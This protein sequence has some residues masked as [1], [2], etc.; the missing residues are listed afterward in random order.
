VL[1]VLTRTGRVGRAVQTVSP[2]VQNVGC[3]VVSWKGITMADVNPAAPL[4]PASS[5][6]LV[7][8]SV[9]LEVLGKDHVFETTVNGEKDAAGNVPL[10]YLVGG[11]DPVLVS[12]E[13][14]PTERYPTTS[15]TSLEKLA[16][17]VVAAGVRSVS[18]GIVGV[19][20]RYD[21]ERYVS[22]WP[23]S[24]HGIEGGPL[25]ALMVNDGVVIGEAEKRD[26][27]AVAAAAELGRVLAKRGVSVGGPPQRGTVPEGSPRIAGITSAPLVSIVGEML[28]NSDNNT[29]EL[30]L[31]ELG[32]SKKGAGTTAFGASVV[33]ETLASWNLGTGVAIVDGS[34]L[35]REN[36]VPCSLFL[37][38][39]QREAPV[40]PPLMAVAGQS[41]TLRDS[42]TKEAIRG[43]LL[44]KTGTLSDV[45][46]L[47]GY[48][49][50]DGD[51]PV[52][53]A[54]VLNSNGIDNQSAYRPVWYALGAALD[55]A[56]GVPKPEQLVP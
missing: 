50:V 25:G 40:L 19:D 15:G 54:L 21:T 9:A 31:K 10:L 43:R 35:S 30:L 49:P 28:T 22:T 55:R 5:V 53:Y 18:G 27:P 48:V 47:V 23:A 20:S 51:D 52:F 14:P 8:A 3:L 24:F 37:S 1:S 33:T 26:D 56:R 7:T 36:K 44:G 12:A 11:G 38:L 29:A 45:K 2:L 6:K 13:Y 46:A 41:G 42:F 17:A 32:L 39:L 34:G 16:D 4:T